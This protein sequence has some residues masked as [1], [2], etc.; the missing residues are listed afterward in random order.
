MFKLS[1]AGSSQKVTQQPSQL[2]HPHGN[3]VVINRGDRTSV[4]GATIPLSSHPCGMRRDGTVVLPRDC[5]IP[6]QATREKD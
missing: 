2:A 1:L 5:S 4:R 3:I 6:L